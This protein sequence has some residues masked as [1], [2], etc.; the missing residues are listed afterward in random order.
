MS[1]AQ[2]NLWRWLIALSIAA[3][4]IAAMF[5]SLHST[6][7][8]A[9]PPATGASY[10]FRFDANAQTF[11]TI[12][13][14]TGS[15][16]IGVAVTGTQPT[17]VWLTEMG[18]NQIGHVIYTDT[19]DYQLIEYPVTST[20]SSAPFRL[21]IDG[22]EVWFTERGANRIGR[23][24]AAT[25][26]IDE[27]YGHGLSPNSGLSDI[28][29]APNGWVWIGGQWSK[30]LV[31]LIV[32]STLVYAFTEY[33]DTARPTFLVAPYSLAIENDD[34]I[35]FTVPDAAYYKIGQ[36]DVFQ[37]FFQWPQGFKPGSAA[38]EVVVTPGEVWV[39][40]SG[41]NQLIQ[42]ELGTL[43]IINERGPITQ[44]LGL[45]AEAPH[46]LWVAQQ[47]A[48]G[49]I[50]RLIYTAETTPSTSVGSFPLPTA[51]LY[52]TGIAVADDQAVWLAAYQATRLY[53]P[54]ITK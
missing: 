49:A 15:T 38:Q 13:L 22:S 54:I 32:T 10:L 21:T 30:R 46:R 53:L 4:S 24:D 27:F 52:L 8:V 7:A 31:R 26:Q 44:P 3:I 25:G 23:L 12:P 47:T 39:S 36:F 11:V 20:S 14:P 5:A 34:S 28:K 18:R 6:P 16:P 35:W 43:P 2:R 45:A 1:Q 41:R 40:D 29:V 48:Q 19:N 17:H 42:I 37:R 9:G 51:G 33:T 50:G